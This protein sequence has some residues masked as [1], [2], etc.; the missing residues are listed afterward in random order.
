MF[1][2]PSPWPPRTFP[3]PAWGRGVGNHE[4]LDPPQGHGVEGGG[5][6][7][8]VHGPDVLEAATLVHAAP[9][10]LMVAP[11]GSKSPEAVPFVSSA[12]SLSGRDTDSSPCEKKNYLLHDQKFFMGTAAACC[13]KR[14]IIFL[15]F[16]VR[17]PARWRL[18]QGYVVLRTFENV[19]RCRQGRQ[20]LS[21]HRL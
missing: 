2:P 5:H 12:S 14:Q 7:H 15:L 3:I 9:S 16:R 18:W 17:A 8:V 20:R 4:C 6:R 19:R 10:P 1:H 21:R 13:R 11:L